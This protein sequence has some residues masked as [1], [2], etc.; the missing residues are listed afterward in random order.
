M[1]GGV[2]SE[3][4]WTRGVVKGYGYP[5]ASALTGSVCIYR[6]Y[7]IPLRARQVR[8]VGAGIAGHA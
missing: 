2:H 5:A 7:A 8:L 6:Q 4:V 3:G 1:Y